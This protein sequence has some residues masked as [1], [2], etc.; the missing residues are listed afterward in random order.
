MAVSVSPHRPGTAGPTDEESVELSTPV[1]TLV[2]H[3]NGWNTG[4]KSLACTLT[5]VDCG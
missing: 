1:G 4:G 5:G 2:V 3:S